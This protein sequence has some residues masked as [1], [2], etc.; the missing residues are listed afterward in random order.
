MPIKPPR[1]FLIG[2]EWVAGWTESTARAL[3]ELGCTVHVFYYLRT[4]FAQQVHRWRKWLSDRLGSQQKITPAWMRAAYY[5]WA[6]LRA[7]KPI[8]RV[9]REFRPDLIL[10][11]KG[12]ILRQQT[13][14]ELKRTTGA[15][16]ATWWVDDPYA[17]ERQCGLRN[18]V[19]CLPLYDCVFVFDRQCL[20]SLKEQ[21]IARAEFLPCTVDPAVFH[22]QVGNESEQVPLT[23]TVSFVG[24]YFENRGQVVKE[25]LAEEGLRVWG[26]GWQQFSN[27]QDGEHNQVRFHDECVPQDKVLKIY[28]SSV[29]NLNIHHF[30]SQVGGLNN[31]AFEIPA[32]GGFQLTDYVRGMEELFEPGREVAVYESPKELP[33]LV[34]HYL[35]DRQ[36]RE[37]IARAGYERVLAQHTYRHRMTTVLNAL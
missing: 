10:V 16:L 20:V 12:E 30:Q 13:I 37:R 36:S 14:A 4:G 24:T 19:H 28:S 7:S 18:V 15:S 21:G 35:N 8:I 3:V 11:L 22:P 29:I 2:P 1:V 17:F 34:R 33:E 31:R 23:A 6:G 5:Q 32:A 25:L 27:G 26:T 9:A